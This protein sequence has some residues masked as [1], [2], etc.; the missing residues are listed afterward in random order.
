MGS[1]IIND[2]KK[3]LTKAKSKSEKNKEPTKEKTKPENKTKEKEKT[4]GKAK[5]DKKKVKGEKAK[6][7]EPTGP[8]PTW[9]LTRDRLV[10]VRKFQGKTYVDIREYYMDKLSWEIKP[11]QK[12][13][14]LNMEQYKNL[15]SILPQLD[16]AFPAQRE[17]F[18]DPLA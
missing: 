11:G 15:K 2:G 10:K 8:E 7:E 6:D 16:S 14:S 5:P 13:V 12:G 9:N 3:K 18:V 4:K 17:D 1:K